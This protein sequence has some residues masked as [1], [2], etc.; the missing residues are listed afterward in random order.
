MPIALLYP[1]NPKQI[2]LPTKPHHQLSWHPL[3][4][5]DLQLPESLPP[6]HSLLPSLNFMSG[7]L[8]TRFYRVSGIPESTYDIIGNRTKNSH[9]NLLWSKRSG[10]EEVKNQVNTRLPSP[11]SVAQLANTQNVTHTIFEDNSSQVSR[12]SHLRSNVLYRI[13][14]MVFN[15][16]IKI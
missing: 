14:W 6:H 3:M 10:L 7:L 4:G 1:P 11:H 16:T 12:D 2:T 13:K 5:Y 8:C 15:E 9:Q